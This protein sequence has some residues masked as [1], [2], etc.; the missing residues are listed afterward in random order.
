MILLG[1]S[2]ASLGIK[3]AKLYQFVAKHVRA[4]DNVLLG[5]FLTAF[6][7]PN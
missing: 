4:T 1:S 5:T 6:Y 2:L 7:D 3:H